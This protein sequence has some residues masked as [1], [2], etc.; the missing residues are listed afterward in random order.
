MSLL[1]AGTS[2]NVAGRE[3]LS[4]LGVRRARFAM[5]RGRSHGGGWRLSARQD[6]HYPRTP[7]YRDMRLFGV[8]WD[9]YMTWLA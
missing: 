2:I 4:R 1:H 9:E 6:L 3:Y 7:F 5:K 8:I